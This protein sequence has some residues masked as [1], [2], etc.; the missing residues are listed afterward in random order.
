[1]MLVVCYYPMDTSFSLSW[2]FWS[3]VQQRD[4]SILAEGCL[5][6]A[7]VNLGIH[8]LCEL[9]AALKAICYDNSWHNIRGRI[10]Q[11]TPEFRKPTKVN[12]N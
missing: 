1:M 4:G 10:D 11:D 7:T 2:I 6:A 12:V 3:S 9:V 5:E 8:W